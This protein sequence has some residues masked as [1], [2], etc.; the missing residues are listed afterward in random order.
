MPI[1]L[2]VVIIT[3]NMASLLVNA[4]NSLTNQTCNIF[5]VIIVD[6]FS[7][8][9]TEELINKYK[10]KLHIQYKKIKNYGILSKSRNVGI[11]LSHSEWIAFL[12][13]D[14]YWENNKVEILLKV[15]NRIKGQ[16]Y[17]AI[18]H[19][20][21][22]K[23]LVSGKTKKMECIKYN[24]ELNKNLILQ[25][26]FFCLTGTTVKKSTVLELGGFCEEKEIATVEDY[27]MWIRLSKVGKFYYIDKFL[28]TI[29][30]H[31]GNCSKK[32]DIQMKALDTLKHKYIDQSKEF[33]EN[34]K[35]A[36]YKKLY[37]LEAR[38][39]QKNGFFLETRNIFYKA[40]KNKNISLKLIIIY[41]LAIC[42][43]K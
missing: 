12:D 17:V 27:D 4:L 6:N 8:D 25:R 14:D 28:A 34:E 18:T 19:N 2:S 16:N 36:A 3:Y 29:V 23:D 43:I 38:C 13:A 41:I 42:K 35:K 24:G 21:I 40:L 37:S 26:N 10:S 5:E 22:E 20:C 39:L 30:L 7:T 9:G 15:I 11:S 1:N 32:A 33:S 31:K